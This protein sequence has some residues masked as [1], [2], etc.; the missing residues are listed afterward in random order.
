MCG[1]CLYIDGD[2]KLD[3]VANGRTNNG[4]VVWYKNNHPDP[5]EMQVINENS[6]NNPN[7]LLTADIDSD[8]ALDVVVAVEGAGNMVWYKNPNTTVAYAK[9]FE[10]YPKY[11]PPQQ[12]DTLKLIT[13]ISNPENHQVTV[14]TL[15][16]GDQITF[17]DSIELFDDGLHG[18]GEASDNI[19]GANKWL[20][21]LEEQ[22]YT[23]KLYTNDLITGNT[24]LLPSKDNFT[25]VGPIV[26]TDYILL[27]DT[28]PNPG[29]LI[30]FKLELRNNGLT[31]TANNIKAVIS[32]TDS[33][34]SEISAN[35][36]NFGDIPAGE[37]VIP[38]SDFQYYSVEINPNCLGD[39]DGWF[40]VDIYSND[41][42]FWSDSFAFH[43]DDSVTAIQD[44]KNS[45]P[46]KYSLHQNYPNPFN[47]ST[48]IKYTIPQS[49]IP[50]SV[51]DL[52][53]Q[54]PDQARNDNPLIT[55]KVYDILGREVAT[56]VNQKQK[57]G[58]YE[59]DFN[60]YDLTSGIY[61]YQLVS[62]TFIETKKMLMIK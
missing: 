19:F 27:T 51:R 16:S 35:R 47:P 6:L 58:N 25:T 38:A 1:C 11:I 26:F 60:S 48:T 15:I 28:I 43:I 4:K 12:G 54:I 39:S 8:N 3:V 61:F 21:G 7:H 36:A 37:S 40:N 53:T 14:Y 33:C 62:G 13:Q 59:I 52:S 29:D 2:E 17:Q 42:Y 57:P 23:L 22:N 45:L 9:S 55:L 5:W 31:G 46:D 20:A 24:H 41:N 32:T 50:N 34:I 44:E 56:L 30:R 10:V 49:V 18:D